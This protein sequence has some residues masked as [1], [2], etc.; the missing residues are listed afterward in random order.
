MQDG[1]EKDTASLLAEMDNLSVTA[2]KYW[3]NSCRW[4]FYK[5]TGLWSLK[6][7]QSH[8]SERDKGAVGGR[9]RPKRRDVGMRHVIFD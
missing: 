2:W 5:T 6:K 8:E 4:T 3:T 1:N 9:R 7:C